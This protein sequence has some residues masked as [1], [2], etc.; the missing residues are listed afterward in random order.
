[1]NT[2][3]SL[4]KEQ[5]IV[6]AAFI[7]KVYGWMCGAL[8]ITAVISM[9]AVS[10]PAVFD[11]I[12]PAS[13]SNLPFYLLI[14]AEFGAVIYISARINKMS[15]ERASVLF[16]IYSILNGLTLSMIFLIYTSASIGSTFL[17][18]ALTFG[19]MSI[20][21]YTTKKDLTSIGKLAMM[22]L[23]GLIIATVVNIFMQ[24]EVI[25]WIANYAGVLIFVALT[26]YDT[27]KIKQMASFED[28]AEDSKKKAIYGALTLYLDFINMFL[29]LLRIFGDRK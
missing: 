18:T 9:W 19:I 20:Y 22:A 25:Y 6:Q 27:Q 13:G 24:S 11:L 10:T 15:A 16:L 26:A 28:S 2:D 23:I 4:S 17:I 21:G 14:G 29:F 1:M 12:F 5:E 8:V 7:S 3:L